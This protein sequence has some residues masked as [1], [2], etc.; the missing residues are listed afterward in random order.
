MWS[1]VKERAEESAAH[2]VCTIS[3]SE[4]IPWVTLGEKLPF[5]EHIWKSVICL[6]KDKKPAG[7]H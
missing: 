1:K 2:R 4:G 6:S 7:S 3:H 5:L